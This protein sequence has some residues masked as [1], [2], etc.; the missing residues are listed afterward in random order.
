MCARRGSKAINR[1]EGIR[2][3]FDAI[4]Q[5]GLEDFGV[6]PAD[7]WTK[8]EFVAEWQEHKGEKL[9]KHFATLI[10][11][12]LVDSGKVEILSATGNR[13]AKYYRYVT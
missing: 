1:K 2:L 13:G 10:L 7:A 6:R 8:A 12:R 5:M 9:T 11:E 3:A 4:Q